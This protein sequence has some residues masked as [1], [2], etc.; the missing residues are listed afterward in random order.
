LISDYYTESVSIVSEATSTAW[1]SEPVWGTGT[2]IVAAMNPVSGDERFVAGYGVAFATWKMFCSDTVSISVSNRV[3]YS[4]S[5][6]DVVFVKDTLNRG[7]HK[8]ILLNDV[9]R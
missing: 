6:Y 1:G 3:I 2:T 4:G 7:H 5:S 8:M 9:A